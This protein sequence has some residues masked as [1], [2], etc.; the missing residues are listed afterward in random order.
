[1][2]PNVDGAGSKFSKFFAKAGMHK[3]VLTRYEGMDPEPEGCS[4]RTAQVEATLKRLR[5]AARGDWVKFPGITPRYLAAAGVGDV[6]EVRLG[7]AI[8][9][10]LQEASVRSTRSRPSATGRPYRWRQSSSLNCG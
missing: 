7:E 1:M 10:A 4:L 9:R 3:P 6:A 2:V 5:A 8:A